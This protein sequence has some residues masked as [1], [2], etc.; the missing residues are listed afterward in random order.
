MTGPEHYVEAERLASSAETWMDADQG[1]MATL[2]TEERIA[3]RMA[4]L[5]AAQVH[6]ALA[7]AAATALMTPSEHSTLADERAWQEVAGIQAGGGR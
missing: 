1:W 2:P 3:R 5:A 6:A 4:D 7:G